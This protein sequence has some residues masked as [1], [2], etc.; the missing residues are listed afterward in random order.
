MSDMKYNTDQLRDS[1]RSDRQASDAADAA[2]RGL[3]GA[4][5]GAG[6]FGDIDGGGGLAGALG[7][8]QSD[9][10]RAARAAATKADNQAGG[11][12]QT[13]AAGDHLTAATTR[14]ANQGTVNRVADGMGGS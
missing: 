13:A 11:T 10:V 5:I 9:H 8:A 12:D 14:I 6:I 2:G 3:G 4:S 7:S 1:A